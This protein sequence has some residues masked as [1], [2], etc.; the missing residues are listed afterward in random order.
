M[1][2]FDRPPGERVLQEFRVFRD[3][4]GR[5]VVVEKHGEHGGSFDS[6]DEAVHFA[7]WQADGD[8]A[9]V[10]IDPSSEPEWKRRSADWL[11]AAKA[12]LFRRDAR[13]SKERP[14]D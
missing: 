3:P 5:W 11:L 12:A 6:R 1:P 14:A 7:L 10:H 13:P 4:N 9:R 8:P 2:Y